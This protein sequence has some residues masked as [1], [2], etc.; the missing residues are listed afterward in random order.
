MPYRVSGKATLYVFTLLAS[1][2]AIGTGALLFERI[3]G[4]DLTKDFK[5]SA[6]SFSLLNIKSS[7]AAAPSPEDK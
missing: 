6:A 3:Q 1:G 7:K 2:T 4:T 5:Q